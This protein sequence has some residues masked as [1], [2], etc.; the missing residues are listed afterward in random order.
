M[1]KKEKSER[2]CNRGHKYFK[3]SDCPVC[4]I[5]ENERKPQESFLSKVSAPARRALENKGITDLEELSHW[6]KKDLLN[7]HGIGPAAIPVLERELAKSGL[8]F[9]I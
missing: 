6:S 2:I 9:K 4:P 1:P 5:C 3:S 7:L 8:S